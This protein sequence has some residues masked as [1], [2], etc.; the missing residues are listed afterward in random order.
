M[1]YI[2]TKLIT[3]EKETCFYLIGHADDKKTAAAI[4]VAEYKEFNPAAS[5]QNIAMITEWLT[6]KGEYSFRRDKKNRIQLAISE[7]DQNTT[8]VPE[9]KQLVFRCISDDDLLQEISSRL[10]PDGKSQASR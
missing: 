10:C 2:V 7:L 6:M 5:A 9:N 4:A 3:T 1:D 8:K